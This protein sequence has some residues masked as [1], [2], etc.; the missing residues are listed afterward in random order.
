ME[1]PGLCAVLRGMLPWK[2]KAEIYTMLGLQK[3]GKNT[4]YRDF[5]HHLQHSNDDFIIAPT[6][7]A[8]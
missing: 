2:T 7:A 8:W 4:F 6:F 5:M 3:Q 1:V